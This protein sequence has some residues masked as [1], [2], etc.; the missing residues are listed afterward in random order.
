MAVQQRRRIVATIAVLCS[1]I[2]VFTMCQSRPTKPKAP[3]EL[4]AQ[5]KP[6]GGRPLSQRMAAAAELGRS[7]NADAWIV[8]ILM[9]PEIVTGELNDGRA[10][11]LKKFQTAVLASLIQNIR[12]DASAPVLLALARQL[13][14]KDTGRY[15]QDTLLRLIEKETPPI[16]ELARGTL[17]K[18][19]KEDHDY[20]RA[21]WEKAIWNMMKSNDKQVTPPVG[22]S[23]RPA[24]GT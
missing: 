20:D 16:R 19:L 13:G 24:L 8:A 15:S 12:E 2:L 21:V 6:S 23:S 17:E 11:A 3:A 14:N 18:C 7:E 4:V 10:E 5:M 22:A 9:S 1:G